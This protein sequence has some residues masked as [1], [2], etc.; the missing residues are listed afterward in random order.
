MKLTKLL[1]FIIDTKL[2]KHSR[3]DVGIFAYYEIIDVS[4]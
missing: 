1:F 3:R 4:I 2:V